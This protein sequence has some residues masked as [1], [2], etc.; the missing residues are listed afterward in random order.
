[1]KKNTVGTVPKSNEQIVDRCKIET[2]K[3]TH[4]Y[5]GWLSC[6]S[7]GRHFNKK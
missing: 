3:H 5:D 6:L 1:L 2:P 7:T 4:I